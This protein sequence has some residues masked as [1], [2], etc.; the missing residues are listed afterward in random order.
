M[1]VFSPFG[2]LRDFVLLGT[3]W[4]NVGTGVTVKSG[5]VGAFDASAGCE[6]TL[7]EPPCRVTVT[8]S[9]DF[10][11]LAPFNIEFLG[12]EIGIPTTISFT[13]DSTFAMTDIELAPAP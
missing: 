6:E 10:R 12:V 5:N 13:R 8:L 4:V 3:E 1:T 2:Y 9:H 11:L 7:R